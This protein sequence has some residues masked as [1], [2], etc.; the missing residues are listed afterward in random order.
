M[1]NNDTP[2][3]GAIHTGA[4]GIQR[5][6]IIAGAAW[7]IPV[8]AVA[9]GAPLAAASPSPTLA[10]TNGP[11]D[12]AACGTLKDVTLLLTANGTTPDP[13]K[14]VTVTLPS[15]L[16]W[17]DGTTNPKVLTTDANG[18]ITLSGIKAKGAAGNV[19][20][21]ATSSTGPQTSAVVTVTAATSNAYNATDKSA[22]VL[23]PNVPANSTPIGN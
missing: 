20:I 23:R 4:D 3:T 12:V 2:E 8:V 16:T 9:V 18:N 19:S 14:I 13:G 17:S 11:Y 15:G 7:T 1:I 10:F 21:A 6:T 5:R 22:G